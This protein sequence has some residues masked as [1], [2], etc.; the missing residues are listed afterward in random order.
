MK[1]YNL[2][3]FIPSYIFINFGKF[4]AKSLFH[5][6]KIEIIPACTALFHP[7]SKSIFEIGNKNTDFWN[8]KRDEQRASSQGRTIR[9]KAIAQGEC[10]DV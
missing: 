4:Q 9:Y 1:T 2:H 8:V 3:G 6:D 5:N 10:E 7:T